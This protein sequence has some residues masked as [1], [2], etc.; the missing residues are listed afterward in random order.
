ME[1]GL[2]AQL[3]HA[4]QFAKLSTSHLSDKQKY[5]VWMHICQIHSLQCIKTATW[6]KLKF[7]SEVRHL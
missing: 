6:T 1:T 7:G 4:D 5:L 2:S 3:I